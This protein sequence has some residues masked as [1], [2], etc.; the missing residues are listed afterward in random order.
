MNFCVAT[1]VLQMRLS[2]DEAITAATRGGAKAL[3]RHNV[4]GGVDPQGRPAVG[5]LAVG[6]RCNLHVLNTNH[7]QVLY[8]N[9]RCINT[10]LYIS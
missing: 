7:A 8:R 10:V 2:L 6:A 3:R 9:V 5:T 4:G 1:A